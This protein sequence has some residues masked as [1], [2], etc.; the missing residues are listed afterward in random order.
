MYNKKEMLEEIKK[1][2]YSKYKP[3]DKI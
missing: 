3:E 1:L 2:I